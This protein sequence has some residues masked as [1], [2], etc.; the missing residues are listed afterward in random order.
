L[1]GFYPDILIAGSKVI[2]EVDGKIHDLPANKIS[3]RNRTKALKSY[4]YAIVRCTNYQVKH[5]PEKIVQKVCEAILKQSKKH[6]KASR[7]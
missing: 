2:L 3:D 4:G 6:K 1:H 7:D 5:S